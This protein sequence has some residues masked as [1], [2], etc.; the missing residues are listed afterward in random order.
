MQTQ[1]F[2]HLAVQDKDFEMR[3]RCWKFYLPLYFALQKTNNPRFGSSY[4]KVV[5]NIEKIYAG[6]KYLLEKNGMSVQ[7][8]DHSLLE[9]KLSREERKI[10]RDAKTLG[11]IKPQIVQL[12]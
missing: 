4:V 11:G 10:N 5:E 8:Q 12:F 7:A 2:L 1:H 9:L 3:L 6:L